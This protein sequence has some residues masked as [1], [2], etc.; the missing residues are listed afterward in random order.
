MGFLS[1][2]Q[3]ALHY[4]VNTMYDVAHEDYTFHMITEL[5]NIGK[6]ESPRF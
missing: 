3:F 1:V 5:C 4:S 6:S 2:F